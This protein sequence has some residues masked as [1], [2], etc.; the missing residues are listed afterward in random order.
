MWTVGKPNKYGAVR[1]DGYASKVEARRAAELEVLVRIGEI[2]SFEEQVPIQLGPGFRMIV[3]FVIVEKGVTFAE[4]VKGPEPQRFKDI[5]RMWAVYGPYRM[6]ILKLVN[7]QW[8]RE[9]LEGATDE[10]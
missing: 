3:D 7:G 4:E 10:V 6:K 2:D 1:T 8:E 5:R 9:W